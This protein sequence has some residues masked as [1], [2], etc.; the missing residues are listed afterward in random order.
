MKE[1]SFE[2]LENL[3]GGKFWGRS[4]GPAYEIAGQCYRTCARYMFWIRYDEGPVGCA[5]A[6]QYA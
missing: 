1:L 2:K 3:E 4:C 6:D 5:E